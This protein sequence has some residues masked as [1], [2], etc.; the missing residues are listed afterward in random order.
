MA[1]TIC[2]TANLCIMGGHAPCYYRHVID[3]ATLLTNMGAK[4]KGAGTDV[5]RIDG[6]DQLHGCQ[7]TIIPDRI[8]AGTY[9]ILG[10]AVGEGVLIDNVIPQ[11]LESLI[12]KLREMGVKIEAGDDQV[13]VGPADQMKAVD[14]KTLVYNGGTVQVIPHI[15]NEIK[16]RVFRAGHETNSD[17]VITEIGG[18]VGDIES[19][20]FFEIGD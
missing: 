15:T 11:H 3:V 2:A 17:V 5:I 10:A 19:L 18:T 14:I 20:P 9:M 13:F 8:E 6:V 4:I 7:H 16:D 1:D 12:A